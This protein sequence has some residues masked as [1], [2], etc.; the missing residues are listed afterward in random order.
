MKNIRFITQL[1]T[2]NTMLL[3]AACLMGLGACAGTGVSGS[4][5]SEAA[6]MQKFTNYKAAWNRHDVSAVTGFY[7]PNGILNDPGAGALSGPALAGW[8]QGLFTAIPD[9]KVEVKTANATGQN[10]ASQFFMKGTWTQP[11]PG[12]P[13]A[14]AKPTGK[15]FTVPASG[16]Y[17]WKNG[18]IMMGTLYFD[19]MSMLTQMGVI[20]QK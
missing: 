6:L 7:Q 9:F 11:F 18:K 20:A 3:L 16:F 13:L 2:Q 19:Q 10:I 5:D 15:A 12:G 1:I 4:A 14:G 17:E 8:V